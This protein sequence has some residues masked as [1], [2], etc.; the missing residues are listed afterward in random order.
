MSIIWSKSLRRISL[1]LAALVVFAGLQVIPS[2]FAAT[3]VGVPG[4]TPVPG[5]PLTGTGQVTRSLLTYS[6]LT[7]TQD[8]SSP[9]NESAFT[10]PDNAAMPAFTFEGTL[11]LNNIASIGG[12]KDLIGCTVH[13]FEVALINASYCPQHLPPFTMDYVQNGSYLIPTNQS[14]IITGDTQNSYVKLNLILGAGRVWGEAT[15]T[16]AAGTFARAS[17]PITVIEVNGVDGCSRNGVLSFLFNATSISNVRYQVTH[18]TCDSTGATGSNYNLWG[19]LS[20]TYKPHQ[21]ANDLAIAN[22]QAEQIKNQIPIKPIEALVTDYPSSNVNI[23]TFIT[24]VPSSAMSVWGVVYNNVNYIGGCQTRFG[25]YPYCSEMVVPSQSTAK[26]FFASLGLAYLVKKY[27]ESVLNA[28]LSTYIPEMA[29]DPYW[30]DSP[31]TLRDASNMATGN[32]ISTI[33][34][35]AATSDETMMAAYVRAIS[36]QAKLQGAMDR[37]PHPGEAGTTMVYQTTATFLLLQ[38]ETGFLQSKLGPSADLFNSMLRDVYIPAGVS[39]NFTTTRTDNASVQGSN[40]TSGRP[41][42][43]WCVFLTVEDMA[44]ITQLF[45]NNGMVNGVQLVDRTQMLIAMQR[46]ISDTGVLNVTT[47]AIG[48]SYYSVS[49]GGNLYSRG[50]W[51][52]PMGGIIKGCD[53]R[54]PMFQ[55]HG[56]INVDLFPNGISTYDFEDAYVFM[57]GWATIEVNKLLPICAPTT[58]SIS[59]S[60][61][62][63]GQDQSVTLTATVSSSKRSWAP[64]GTV[65]FY[66][67]SQ[68]ISPN[69]LLDTN[70]LAAFS[71]SSLTLGTHSVTAV[72]SPDVTNNSGIT[73]SPAVTQL[74][75]TCSTTATTCSVASTAGMKVGDTIAMGTTTSTDDVHIISSLTSSTISWIGALQNASHDSGQ[76]VWVQNTAGGG[77]N[78]STSAG[79]TQTVQAAAVTTTTTTSTTTTTTTLPPTTTTTIKKVVTKTITCVKGKLSKKVTAVNPVCP[80]GYKKK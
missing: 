78:T 27:G 39:M 61:A 9:I 73:S 44:R 64:T 26:A 38:A 63:I 54:L 56:G 4:A 69:I 15:D 77:F 68:A 75:A 14:E 25:T 41:F 57:G 50:V 80:A 53:F 58:T 19:Q 60:Y 29:A 55:G 45:Q 5:D 40:P 52:F 37:P 28:K 6:D 2:A 20:A 1:L 51:A 13:D 11:T 35:G 46:S 74:S 22:A 62:T 21:V 70:G 24:G 49:A 42:G 36:Y 59:S 32:Y 10:I 31:A 23:A 65:R 34:N 72:Y 8:P 76:P 17:V 7:T 71:T 30:K 16:G 18:E 33:N 12:F 3:S 43:G 67:G 48:N 47:D 79:F 66:E